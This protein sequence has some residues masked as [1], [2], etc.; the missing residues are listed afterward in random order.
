M[1]PEPL[2]AM[3][4]YSVN[5]ELQLM[6]VKGFMIL[7]SIQYSTVHNSLTALIS[8]YIAKNLRNTVVTC[9]NINVKQQ[10]R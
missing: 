10:I 1:H 2:K 5:G 4:A 6:L 7:V 9:T 3:T 8:S